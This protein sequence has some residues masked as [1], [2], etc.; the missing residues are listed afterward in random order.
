MNT[1]TE[2]LVSNA[3]WLAEGVSHAASE[4]F[5]TL[6]AWVRAGVDLDRPEPDWEALHRML[7]EVINRNAFDQAVAR[8]REIEADRT[9]VRAAGRLDAV[10]I[11][12]APE[13][14]AD[15]TP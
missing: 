10:A 5:D 8:H 3:K 14:V 11:E 2:A 9:D 15:V 4:A 12:L 1:D 6:F 13:Y 7:A